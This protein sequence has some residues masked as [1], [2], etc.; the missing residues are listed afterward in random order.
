MNRIL[1]IDVAGDPSKVVL[2]GDGKVVSVAEIKDK[3]SLSERLLKT[4]DD[5][6]GQHNTKLSDLAAVA[7]TVEG[8]SFTS[9]RIAAAVVNALGYAAQL[10]LIALAPASQEKLIISAEKLLAEGKT[11]DRLLPEYG[12]PPT[13]T[14]PKR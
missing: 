8:S 9:L 5:V 13:I 6:L 10:P 3:R 14:P 4:I 7:L 1:I 11:T 12:R 2:A